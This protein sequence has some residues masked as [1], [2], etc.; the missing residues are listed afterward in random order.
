VCVFHIYEIINF[1]ENKINH[2]VSNL[3]MHSAAALHFIV[4]VG[5]GPSAKRFKNLLEM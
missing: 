1:C 5:F 3:F 4:M 2:K